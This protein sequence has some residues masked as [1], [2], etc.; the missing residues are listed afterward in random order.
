MCVRDAER[1][2]HTRIGGGLVKGISGG[3]RKRTSIGYEILV[4]PSLLL[5]DEPTSGLDSSSARKERVGSPFRLSV[6]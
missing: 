1:C 5:L 2:H 6:A 4:D 3:E